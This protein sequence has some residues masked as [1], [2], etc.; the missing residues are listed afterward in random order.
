M[1]LKILRDH[2]FY[3]A[4]KIIFTV[5]IFSKLISVFNTLLRIWNYRF[6]FVTI[7]L[8]TYLLAFL[9]IHLHSR[10]GTRICDHMTKCV[11]WYACISCFSRVVKWGLKLGSTRGSSDIPLWNSYI[12]SVFIFLCETWCCPGVPLDSPTEELVFN[13]SEWVKGFRIANCLQIKTPV[14]LLAIGR[15]GLYRSRGWIS[16][17]KDNTAMCT[18]WSPNNREFKSIS[19]SYNGEVRGG[20]WPAGQIQW[21]CQLF[22]SDKRLFKL[23]DVKSTMQC[24]P[25]VFFVFGVHYYM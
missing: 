8:K 17:W 9:Q 1:S 24:L 11:T 21:Y 5:A 19:N 2:S 22:T 14:Q 23:S 6:M 13:G 12:A 18:S 16:I 7:V 3:I 10:S 25:H 15:V 20:E 4:L